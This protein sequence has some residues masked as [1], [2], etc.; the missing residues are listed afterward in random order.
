MFVEGGCA[1]RRGGVE[2]TGERE[3]RHPRHVPRA[4]SRDDEGGRAGEKPFFGVVSFLPCSSFFV[5]RV[6]VCVRAIGGEEGERE[7]D[8]GEGDE[9]RVR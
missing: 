5:R 2:G 3:A 4:V 7:T 9:E 1:S 6:G 8:V